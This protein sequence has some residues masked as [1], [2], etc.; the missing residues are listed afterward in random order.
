VIELEFHYDRQGQLIAETLTGEP[1]RDKIW[2]KGT[3]I[4]AIW[5]S[6]NANGELREIKDAYLVSDQPATPRVV[7]GETQTVVW[8]WDNSD[9]FGGN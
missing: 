5:I 7:V 8:R 1:F 2:V 3:P 4:R 9:G 6:A